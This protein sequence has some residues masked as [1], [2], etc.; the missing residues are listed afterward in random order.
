MDAAPEPT[1]EKNE[2]TP[3][4]PPGYAPCYAQGSYIEV[5]ELDDKPIL[6]I[7]DCYNTSLLIDP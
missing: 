6:V 1:Y 7:H 4:P 5:A 3:P 2:S